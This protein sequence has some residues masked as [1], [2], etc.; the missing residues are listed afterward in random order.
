MGTPPKGAR[1]LMTPAAGLVVLELKIVC[2]ATLSVRLVWRRSS[3]LTSTQLLSGAPP[4]K[5]LMLTKGGSLRIPA[6]AEFGT[7][8][9]K[10][11]LPELTW[12]L[13]TPPLAYTLVMPGKKL[14]LVPG[15]VW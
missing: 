8:P 11:K 1:T 13:G 2:W 6:S 7:L 5:G 3:R 4:K 9:L 15:A 14:E 12:S 10:L